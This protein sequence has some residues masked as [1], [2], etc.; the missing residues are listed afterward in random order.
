VLDHKND[1]DQYP[2]EIPV[3]ELEKTIDQLIEE[4]ES[5]RKTGLFLLA[6]CLVVVIIMLVANKSNQTTTEE[7]AREQRTQTA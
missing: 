7:P 6:V 3:P 5:A 2:A 4:A 1:I